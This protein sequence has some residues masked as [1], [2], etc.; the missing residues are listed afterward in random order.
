MI[1]FIYFWLHWVSVSIHGLFYLRRA[2][3]ALRCRALALGHV[4][5]VVGELGLSCPAAGRIFPDWGL[6]L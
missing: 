2:G 3:A 6:N 1:S 5:S 4:S